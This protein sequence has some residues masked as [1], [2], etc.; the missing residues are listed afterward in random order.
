MQRIVYSGVFVGKLVS[1][2]YDPACSCDGAKDI[3]RQPSE[4]RGGSSRRAD[5]P[6]AL[7]LGEVEVSKRHGDCVA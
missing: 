5:E 3:R 6:V 1:E 7:V 4:C 2:V